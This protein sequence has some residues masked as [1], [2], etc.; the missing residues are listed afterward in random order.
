M[1]RNAR[2]TAS[3]FTFVF[4]GCAGAQSSG[5]RDDA[6]SVGG[7]ASSSESTGGAGSQGSDAGS[8]STGQATDSGASTSTGAADTTSSTS[9]ASTTGG[10]SGAVLDG[11]SSSDGS[12]GLLESTGPASESTGETGEIGLIDLADYVVAQTSSAREI[13]LPRDTFV[14]FGGLLVIGRDSSQAEFEAFWGVTLAANVRYINAVDT[15]PALNGGETVSIRDPGDTVIDGPSPPL[16]LSTALARIDADANDLAAWS[17]SVNPD[18]DATPGIAE[19]IGGSAG[20][21]FVSEVVDAAGGG[22]YFYEYVEIAV[23]N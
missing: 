4:V 8:T 10:S 5:G 6:A 15:F 12:T 18:A 3:V 7:F 23:G 16:E 17:E 13:V 21:P 22:N 20:V 9:T 19:A 1:L 11:S 2:T 14:S